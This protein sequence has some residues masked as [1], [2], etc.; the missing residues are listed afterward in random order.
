MKKETVRM[1]RNVAAYL[2]LLAM[3]FTGISQSFQKTFDIPYDGRVL[4]ADDLHP[5]KIRDGLYMAGDLRMGQSLVVRA[6]KDGIDCAD[7]IDKDFI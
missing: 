1:K 7:A 6:I 4:P 2:L 5:Y 3:G